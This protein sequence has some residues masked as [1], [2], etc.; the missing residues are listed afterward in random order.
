MVNMCEYN[1]HPSS[2]FGEFKALQ[3]NNSNSAMQ[4][5]FDVLEPLET[6]KRGRS[7][8]LTDSQTPKTSPLWPHQLY[9]WLFLIPHSSTSDYSSFPI[10]RTH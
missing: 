7:E 3:G 2:I 8:S 9:L 4:I 5:L 1:H 10:P 6:P